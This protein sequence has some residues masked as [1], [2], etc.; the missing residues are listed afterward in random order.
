MRN[1]VLVHWL[2]DLLISGNNII[3]SEW[4]DTCSNVLRIGMIIIIVMIIVAQ[5]TE[6]YKKWVKVLYICTALWSS[7]IILYIAIIRMPF[8]CN[9][10]DGIDQKDIIVYTFRVNRWT[11]ELS[12]IL[13]ITYIAL[14]VYALHKNSSKMNNN[15]QQ[16][17]R[18]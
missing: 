6:Q 18:S 17:E 8:L 12:T 9:I 1:I 3:Q 13:G 5:T 4:V 2:S 7:I 11:V 15:I 14:I 10:Y 16:N